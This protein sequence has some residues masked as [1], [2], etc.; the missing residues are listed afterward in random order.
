MKYL[1]LT[2]LL[3]L[4]IPLA[5]AAQ[6]RCVLPVPDGA[7][8][9]PSPASLSGRLTQVRPGRVVVRVARGKDI[10]VYI[11]SHTSLFT[12][13]GGEVETHE[14]E[15][16]QYASIWL[17]GCANPGGS[18]ALAVYL[19]LCSLAAEPCQK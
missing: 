18:T 7:D 11:N 14:L 3:V 17:K 8:I 4:S 19:E 12:A 5:H 16:G 1:W 2:I 6:R 15:V 9:E 13:Y 10:P